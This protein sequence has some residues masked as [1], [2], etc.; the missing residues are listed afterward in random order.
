[1]NVEIGIEAVQFPENEY[2]TGIFFAVQGLHG[3]QSHCSE[4][5]SKGISVIYF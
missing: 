5:Q 3:Q 2:I 4:D 1:M